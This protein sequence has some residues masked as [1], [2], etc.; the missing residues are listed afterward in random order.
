MPIASLLSFGFFYGKYK[1]FNNLT[2]KLPGIMGLSYKDAGVD[3]DA[4]NTFVERIKEA[5]ASTHR[6]EV[7]SDLGGF[8]G[9]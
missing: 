8:G 1:E 2:T 9:I 3:I 7:V 6:K 4:G 5:V